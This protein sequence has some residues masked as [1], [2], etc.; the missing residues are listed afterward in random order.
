MAFEDPREIE[1]TAT[2]TMT[3]GDWKRL[4]DHLSKAPPVFPSTHFRD[5]IGQI[6]EAANKQSQFEAV[7]E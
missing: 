6:A 1:V 5:L 7:E 3:V 2:F 4:Y